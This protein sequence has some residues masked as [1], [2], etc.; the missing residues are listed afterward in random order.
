MI[1]HRRRNP[2]FPQG[3]HPRIF[4]VSTLV[5][6]NLLVHRALRPPAD[7]ALN[8][9]SA[10][11]LTA[12][13]LRVGST[14]AELGLDRTDLRRGLE[15]GS[16]A[17]GCC[18]V[19]VGI[20]AAFPPTRAFF[21]DSRLKDMSRKEIAY[22]ASLRIPVAIALA[23]EIMFR[24]ALHALFAR[25]HTLRSTLGWT[26]LLFGLGHI[27][28]TLD[29]FEGNPASD[30]I[31][32][33]LRARLLAVIGTTAMTAAAGL[34]FSYLRLRSKSVAAPVLAHAAINVTAL[35]IGKVLIDRQILLARPNKYLRG[36]TKIEGSSPPN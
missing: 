1:V 21:M 31:Q 16:I 10:V 6:H 14:S 27:L 26:S 19:G 35:V 32:D 23:E 36:A 24:S 3:L 20:A 29:M 25:E 9:I 11:G 15:T 30:L 17:A 34:F 28:P 12:Y 2:R 13:A 22:H 5:V 33:P 8:L 7:A 4:G 18:T